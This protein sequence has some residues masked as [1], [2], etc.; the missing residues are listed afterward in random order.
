MQKI[1]TQS[2][3]EDCCIKLRE[4]VTTDSYERPGP[5]VVDYD[6]IGIEIWNATQKL[7]LPDT[8]M[9]NLAPLLKAYA[10]FL[11]QTSYKYDKRNQSCLREATARILRISLRVAKL[12]IESMELEICSKILE[13]AAIYEYSFSTVKEAD[14]T[15]TKEPIVEENVVELQGEYHLLRA[16]LAWKQN[17]LDLVE[18][19][20]KDAIAVECHQVEF[21]EGFADL[22]CEMGKQL[23]REDRYEEAL[24]RLTQASD[25]INT[26]DMGMMTQEIVDLKTS[27]LR[28]QIRCLI[29]DPKSQNMMI[30][31]NLYRDLETQC[32]PGL[33]LA[34]LKIEILDAI[35]SKSPV[36]Y[37]Q[38]IEQLVKSVQLTMTNLKTILVQLRKL[39][40]LDLS[41]A[42]ATFDNSLLT[43]VIN[44]GDTS[45]IE[46]SIMMR[47]YM[48]TSKPS[49]DQNISSLQSFLDKVQI[50]TNGILISPDA[51]TAADIMIWKCIEDCISANLMDLAEKWCQISLHALFAIQNDLKKARVCRKAM[52]VSLDLGRAELAVNY[53]K[54]MPM[55]NQDEPV[56][57][58]LLYRVAV[59]LSDEE[60]AEQC[61]DKI[62]GTADD[63]SS[64]LYA[65]IQETVQQEKKYFC[66]KILRRI[67]DHKNASSTSTTTIV[68]VLLRCMVKLC[69]DLLDGESTD[70]RSVLMELTPLYKCVLVN[71]RN[72]LSNGLTD[73]VKNEMRWFAN[74][75]HNIL[76]THH[77]RLDVDYILTLLESYLEL[78]STLGRE[79]GS[80]K[81]SQIVTCHY[82]LTST[83]IV[84]ARSADDSNIKDQH[85]HSALQHIKACKDSRQEHSSNH[86]AQQEKDIA[87][88]ERHN[89]QMLQFEIEAQLKSKHWDQLTEIFSRKLD[90]HDSKFLAVLA[91]LVLHTHTEMI[92]QSAD[93]VFFKTIPVV[94]QNII[95]QTWNSS[96]GDMEKLSRWLRCLFRMT[97]GT[98]PDIALQL[99]KQAGNM[100]VKSSA[101]L[102]KRRY[103]PSEIE[104][105]VATTFNSAVDRFCA[106]DNKGSKTWAEAALDLAKTAGSKTGLYEQIQTRWKELQ[107]MQ[108]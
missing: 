51:S 37:Q 69:M 4:I 29:K 88:L 68:F 57:R 45:L 59:R 60:L 46:R 55:Q 81:V 23:F 78:L 91:D 22:L 82:L 56:S 90:S 93:L 106:S 12:C 14:M 92:H 64:Y 36:E 84:I 28:D 41:T 17:R 43:R 104:W 54:R 85:Y 71:L 89:G 33:G 66:I 44:H 6:R 61:L 77:S 49:D 99:L 35:D 18:R 13:S 105:L 39:A 79:D 76:L 75:I 15:H 94:M 16:A 11:L 73:D 52:I 19:Q 38:I 10:L 98:N 31:N 32:R 86:Q 26:I 34:L 100:A 62:M 97:I 83:H 1:Y 47:I 30:A 63:D 7:P 2:I 95:N 65:C 48:S 53:W 42:L 96:G 101:A 67:L 103:P 80:Y 107:K 20:L 5:E 21:V 25:I 27:I 87:H 74:S 58:Y 72:S 50:A 24:S 9:A 70:S 8:K 40:D 108:E 3:D 102:G